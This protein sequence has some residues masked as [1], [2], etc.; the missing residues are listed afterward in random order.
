[1]TNKS[2]EDILKQIK[3]D[4]DKAQEILMQNIPKD[5]YHH[6]NNDFLFNQTKLSGLNNLSKNE[7]EKNY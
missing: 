1:M 5:N 4:P 6:I 7:Q 2:I 3:N